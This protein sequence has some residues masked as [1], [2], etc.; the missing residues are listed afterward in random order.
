ML[1][2]LFFVALDWKAE[3]CGHTVPHAGTTYFTPNHLVVEVEVL[4][5]RASP[6]RLSASQFQLRVNGKKELL[7]TET[8]GMVANSLKYEDWNQGPRLQ[9]QAG[10]VVLGAPRTQPRFPGAPQPQPRPLPQTT[11]EKEPAKTDA[12]AVEE[13]ALPEGPTLGPTKGLIY[14]PYRGKMKSLKSA[15]L[16]WEGRELKLH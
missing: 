15:T 16:L 13:A 3:L 10:P 1:P 14:F 9:G 6:I 12:E 2:L 11:P 7:A 4:P 8:P 5:D